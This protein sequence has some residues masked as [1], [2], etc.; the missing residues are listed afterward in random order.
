MY[1]ALNLFTLRPPKYKQQNKTWDQAPPAEVDFCPLRTSIETS[2]KRRHPEKKARLVLGRKTS[3]TFPR[4]SSRIG[5]Y[6]T[7][8]RVVYIHDD[9]T[10]CNEKR[11]DLQHVNHVDKLDWNEVCFSRRKQALWMQP[12]PPT[13]VE[14]T[15]GSGIMVLARHA[16][17]QAKSSE[18][19]QDGILCSVVP[20]A[21]STC[22]KW[23][24]TRICLFRAALHR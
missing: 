12:R 16:K 6:S 22:T 5:E 4:W 9:A 7:C 21:N 18:Q 23:T 17:C 20:L 10:W 11:Y 3:F 13:Y 8:L 2:W 19:F 24:N 15:C 1:I 14:N